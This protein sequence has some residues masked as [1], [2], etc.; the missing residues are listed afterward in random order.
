MEEV[1]LVDKKDQVVG[2][3]E[4]LEAHKKGVLHR[5]FSVFIFNSAGQLLLQKRALKKYHSGGLWSNTCCSHPRPGEDTRDAAAR[6]LQEEMGLTSRLKKAFSFQYKVKFENGLT[7]NEFDHV[8]VGLCEVDP[9]PDPREV[10]DWKFI[11]MDFVLRDSVNQP[12]QY[13]Y[14]FRKS[15]SKVLDY[16]HRNPVK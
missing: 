6:R 14:W 12:E 16:L 7:E 5:A 8:F 10:A 2:S 1:I 15:I 9:N 11:D 3:M 13:T 4:K